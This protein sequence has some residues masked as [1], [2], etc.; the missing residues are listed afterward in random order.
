MHLAQSNLNSQ[1]KTFKNLIIQTHHPGKQ[2]IPWSLFK[3]PSYIFFTLNIILP[4]LLASN[5]TFHP[6]AGFTPTNSSRSP[7]SSESIESQIA[8][9]HLLGSHCT[10]ASAI[11]KC[12][13]LW[14]THSLFLI[15]VLHNTNCI[16]FRLQSDKHPTYW[17]ANVFWHCNITIWFHRSHSCCSVGEH[18]DNCSICWCYFL[19]DVCY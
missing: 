1:L 18:S 4:H 9:F 13:F 17:Q 19:C 15:S 16:F 10:P 3:L 14:F 5:S 7:A 2:R 8:L 11:T 6:H 12:T